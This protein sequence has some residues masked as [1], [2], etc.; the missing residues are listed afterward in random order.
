[1]TEANFQNVTPQQQ[2]LASRTLHNCSYRARWVG[3]TTISWCRPEC[4]GDPRG[5]TSRNLTV[6]RPISADTNGH[7][8]F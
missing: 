8:G 3:R 2:V 6:A 4:N 1:M 5:L 7:Y